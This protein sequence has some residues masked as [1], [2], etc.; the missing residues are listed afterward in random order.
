MSK[1]KVVHKSEFVLNIFKFEIS[2]PEISKKAQ[3]GQFVLVMVDE[4]SEK[5]PLTLVDW[6]SRKG[7]ITLF[8]Q[9]LGLST[10]KMAFMEEGD[11]FYS[12]VG[13]LGEPAIM[14]NFGTVVVGGGCFGVGATLPIVKQLKKLGNHVIAIIEAKTENMIYFEEEFGAISDE[15]ILV[16][17]DGSKGESGHIYDVLEE[18]IVNQKRKIDHIKV[19]GCNVMMHR[20]SNLTKEKGEIPTYATVT[21]IMVDGTGMCGS[22]RLSYDGKAKFA[23]VDGPEF[24]AHKIDWEELIHVRNTSYISDES[25]SMQNF[26]PQ[27]RSLTKYLEN[28]QEE[29]SS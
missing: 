15:V 9:E 23:C 6:D 18:M 19:I 3:P 27:C 10:S 24:D 13:P 5:I 12:I 17:S 7:T 25:L 22:C 11:S 8:I 4:Y 14:E 26:A 2:V 20:V 29:E 28:T 1:F 21:T 16:T